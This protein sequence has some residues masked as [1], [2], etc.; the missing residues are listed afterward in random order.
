MLPLVDLKQ[1]FRTPGLDNLQD[2]PA[3]TSMIIEQFLDL[4]S[5]YIDRINK[6]RQIYLS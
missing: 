2:F 1:R 4:H 5:Y 6:I 3:M